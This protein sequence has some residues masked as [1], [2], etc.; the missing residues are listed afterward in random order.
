M[1]IKNIEKIGSSDIIPF[2]KESMDDVEKWMKN[3]GKN[4]KDVL[5]I[6]I[7]SIKEFEKIVKEHINNNKDNDIRITGFI[8]TSKK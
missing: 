1:V 2:V 7:S 8:F 6:N 4:I 5:H 3:M